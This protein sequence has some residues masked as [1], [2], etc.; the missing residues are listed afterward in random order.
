MKLVF[1]DL[2][3]HWRVTVY[4]EDGSIV[5]QQT[6]VFYPEHRTAEYFNGWERQIRTFPGLNITSV[7]SFI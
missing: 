6:N 1:E 3:N 5:F 4:N 7:E 2:N